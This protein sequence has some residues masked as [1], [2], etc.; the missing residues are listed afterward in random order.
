LFGHF[1]SEQSNEIE[2]GRAASAASP[3]GEFGV[4]W[5]T[6]GAE[7]ANGSKQQRAVSRNGEDRLFGRRS[8]VPKLRLADAESV[9]FFAVIDLSA[10]GTGAVLRLPARFQPLPIKTAREVFPQAAQPVT[11]VDRVMSPIQNGI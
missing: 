10:K 7:C 2:T 11:F 1:D 9:L 4:D 6:A 3:L 8:K 5:S